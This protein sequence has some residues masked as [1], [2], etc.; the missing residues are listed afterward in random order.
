MAGPPI[1]NPDEPDDPQGQRLRRREDRRRETRRRRLL[2]AAGAWRRGGRARRHRRR[3]ARRRVGQAPGAG[4]SGQGRCA[5]RRGGRKLLRQGSQR[6]AA[7]RLAAPTPARSR[8][9]STTCSARQSRRA[10]SGALRRAAGL[11]PADGLARRARL[12]GGHPRSG[13]ERLVPRRHP[14]AE[15]GRH[16]LRRRLPAAVHLR[17]AGAAQARLAR[18]PEPQGRRLRPLRK[19][20]RG[21]ARAP[22]GSSPRTRSTTWT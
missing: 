3:R 16:L 6:H 20:R 2:A 13:G 18:G 4:R 21:D 22:A 15:T 10:L 1:A 11:P 19:Q 14:A 7:A 12:P 17:A 8:S 5:G 9:S